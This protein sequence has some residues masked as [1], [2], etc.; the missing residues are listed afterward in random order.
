M[1]QA[2]VSLDQAYITQIQANSSLTNAQ[3]NLDKIQAVADIKDA[4][5]KL[6]QQITAA[7]VNMTTDDAKYVASLQTE[8]AAQNNKLA[9]L[10]GT[11]EYTGA[12]STIT[13]NIYETYD[14]LVVADAR[15]KEL[16]VEAA[17][18]V[19]DQTA[20]GITLAQ[21]NIDQANDGIILAQKNSDD[22]QKQIDDSTITA[23]FDGT[24]A[25]VY[26]DQGD[27]IP[28]P[29]YT[30]Q[31]VIYL[32][33]TGTLEVDANI[34]ELDVPAVQTGQT[35]NISIDALPGAALQ[36]T[37]SSISVI[38]NAQTA[39][40]GA[41]AYVVKVAFSVP[42]GLAV[43]AGMNASVNIITQE[44]KNVLLLPG[45]AIK[46]DNQGKTYVQVMNNQNITNQPVVIGIRDSTHTE[47]VSGLKE[48]DKV[49]TGITWSLQ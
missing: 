20:S 32:V 24:A 38:P 34:D 18:K 37:V 48:G 22:I 3:F 8:L 29:A 14:R 19:V 5:T 23:P 4:I 2:K 9:T 26:Y 15:M 40:A 44:H 7:Q 30:P 45:D 17:Q 47:I 11:Y 36:G 46:Q 28:S 25:A 12:N 6:Q 35:A 42:E 33:D 1:E 43:K 39:A 49:L 10:L 27:I 31:I 16:A 21:N 41:I 13:Y